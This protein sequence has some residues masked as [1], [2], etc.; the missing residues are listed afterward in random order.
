MR[1]VVCIKQVPNTVDVKINPKTNNLDREGIVSIINPYDNNAIEAALQLKEKHSA[2]VFVVTMGPP[3]G[4][5]ALKKALAMG[6]DKGYLLCDF[7]MGGADTLATGYALKQAI[8]KIGD[9]DMV[10][11]GRQAV[12]A[13]TGQ[14]GPIVAEFLDMPQVTYASRIEL[15]G[16]AVVVTRLL[17]KTMQRVRVKLPVVITTTKELNE[18]RF[19]TAFGIYAAVD[20][21]IIVWDSKDLECDPN[22]IGK[23][24]SP[25]VVQSI[26]QPQKGGGN[27]TVLAGTDYEIAK[28]IITVLEEN[29][30]L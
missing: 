20:R 15:D 10:L 28:Q 9:V 11:F 7:A 18:P 21:E 13:D 12:D 23:S 30:A 29:N 19:A 16:E 17:E 4:R 2:E 1:I 14:T 6:C 26:F 24:G 27:A 5:R 22:R 8:E 3:Q 25:S